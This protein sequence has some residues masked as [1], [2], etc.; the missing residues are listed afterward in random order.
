MNKEIEKTEI[1]A[2]DLLKETRIL[3]F[4][5]PSIQKLIQVKGWKKIPDRVEQIKQV[6]N[7]VRD[8]ILFGYNESDEIPDPDS[9]Y[10]EHGQEL[11]VIKI[12]V[13]QHIARHMINRNI[14][15]IRNTG[16]NA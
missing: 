2:R 13:Y 11:G 4:L 7:F 1:I 16:V 9:F 14:Q 15:N 6:Y 3:D 5:H 8:E 12:F 10:K